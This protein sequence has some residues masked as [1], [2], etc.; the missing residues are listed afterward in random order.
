MRTARAVNTPAGRHA[1]PSARP[2]RE[3]ATDASRP[4]LRAASE[5]PA[6]CRIAG[7][8]EARVAATGTTGPA[9]FICLCRH[10]RAAATASAL[11]LSTVCQPG[12]T[13]DLAEAAV[14]R[15][16]IGAPTDSGQ[17]FFARLD[18]HPGAAAEGHPDLSGQEE[19]A[20]D[21]GLAY[22]GAIGTSSVGNEALAEL[23]AGAHEPNRNGIPLH[24]LTLSG[25]W[26]PAPAVEVHG[27]IMERAA[28]G[29]RGSAEI[30]EAYALIG[31]GGR[32]VE[33]KAGRFFTEVGR[34]N[35]QHFEDADFVDKAIILTRLF[36]EDQLS[37]EGVRLLW[38]LAADGA[39][40]VIVGIQDSRGETASSFLAE[41]DETI[42]GHALT[43]RDIDSAGDLLYHARWTM[44]GC[45]PD[46]P[47][48][49]LGLSAVTGPNASGSSTR[50]TIVGTDLSMSWGAT[51]RTAH[52]DIELLARRYEAGDPGDPSHEVLGD[53]GMVSHWLWA[54]RPK[55]IAG[56]RFEYADANG[57]DHRTDPQRD[58]RIRASL[59]LTWKP[60]RVLTLRLQYNHDAADHLAGGRARSLW[61]Q[62]RVTLGAHG[63][64]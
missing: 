39:A 15:Q 46:R 52:W 40:T 21:L 6:C 63:G 27:S 58:E 25:R 44:C 34:L 64:H 37:N 31:G 55:W 12:F 33:W 50:T 32:R 18:G 38:P 14:V 53:W 4:S 47:S 41:P 5:I 9:A 54:Y 16:D 29:E 56:M 45:G 20:F 30:E 2:P 60:T 26:R 59:N 42:A 8:P 24:L 7:C 57:G 1:R 43:G 23:Q 11:L 17:E 51:P 28:P 35:A 36:G 19:P 48:W 62:T 61:L 13:V 22:I 10:C 3:T 49:E